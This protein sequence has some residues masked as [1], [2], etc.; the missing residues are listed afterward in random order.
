MGL[1]RR[2]RGIRIAVLSALMLVAL[3]ATSFAAS[4]ASKVNANL[5]INGDA[6][7]NTITVTLDAGNYTVRDTTGVVPGA[8]CTTV[9]PNTATCPAA[10]I[11][12][13][14]INALA[15]DDDITGSASG[16]TINGGDGADVLRG[17]GN[18]DVINGG[19]GDDTI[20]TG[21]GGVLPQPDCRTTPPRRCSESVDAGPGF[22]TVTYADRTQPVKIDLADVRGAGTVDADGTPEGMEG[23]EGVI[24]GRGSDEITGGT[25]G[26]TLNGGPGDAPDLICGNLG[27]DT[28]DY[29]DKTQP[30]SVTLNGSLETDADIV[31]SDSQRV[32]SAR[33]DCRPTIKDYGGPN[34]GLLCAKDAPP[35]TLCPLDASGNPRRDC[36]ADDGVPGEG[37]CVGEDVENIIG[38]PFND[39]LT[40]NSPDPI[41]SLGPRVEPSGQNMLFGRGGDDTLNGQLGPDLLDGGAHAGGD[42]VSYEGRTDA[43][44]A[45]LDGSANDGSALDL[46]PDSNATD[47]IVDTEDLIGGSGNDVLKGDKL[48]NKIFGGPGDD[49]LQGHGHVDTLAGDDGNDALEGGSGDDSM[50]GG[51]GDDNLFGGG[52]NDTHDGGDGSDTADFS[53]ATT[54]VTVTPGDGADD[55]EA[56]KPNTVLSNVEGAIGGLDDDRLF[57]NDGPGTFVGN[58]GNDLMQGRLGADT[59]IGGAG[60]DTVGYGDH[61]GP[62]SVNIAAGGGDGLPDENDNL[63]GDV[64]NIGGSPFADVLSGDGK[65]NT[66]NGGEGNDR[67]SGAEGDDFLAGDMGNDTISGDTGNDTID[68]AEGNDTLNGT[69]GNDTLRGFTGNDVLDGGTGTDVMSGGDGTDTVSYASRSADITVDMLGTPDDGQRGEN[70]QVRTDVESARTGSGDDNIDLLDGAVGSATCGTGSDEV[71]ADL[72]DEIGSGCE[73]GGVSQLSICA[74]SSRSVRMSGSGVVSL[75]MRCLSNARGTVQLRSAGRVKA[76]KGRARRITLGRKSFTGKRNQQLT[77]RVR[78]GKSAR[79]VVKRKRRLRVQATISMRRD[80][81]T[82]TRQRKRTT[83]TLRAR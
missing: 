73:S 6:G 35:E 43:I 5:V 8:G 10:G 33:R 61:P 63:T 77:V 37:D 48:T 69:A 3:P 39:V 44:D 26:E 2:G 52:G 31:S 70:D 66:I 83:F 72:D 12:Q 23:V 20:D 34:N 15:G 79:S 46:N 41:Y 30:V 1:S 17:G 53:D 13:T 76:S 56:G 68:G 27:K 21:L 47:E 50:S 32:T 64:E 22:D 49:K 24:G 28:V 14:Q 51:P 57:G 80:G 25:F 65:L 36:V 75:R 74:P 67:I 40:G 54:P 59:Y 9:D 18:A 45:S 82:S 11:N 19:T 4:T 38:T 71:R 81:S 55:G 7:V 42:A 16:D 60:V 78:V 58:G 62:V 29:S